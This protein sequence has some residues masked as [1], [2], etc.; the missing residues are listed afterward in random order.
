VLDGALHLI[1]PWRRVF[2]IAAVDR[3]QA[4]ALMPSISALQNL[5]IKQYPAIEAPACLAGALGGP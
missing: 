4:L 3:L 1:H 2:G 5:H